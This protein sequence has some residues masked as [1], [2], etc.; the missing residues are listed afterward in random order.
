MRIVKSFF[1]FVFYSVLIAIAVGFFYI[2]TEDKEIDYKTVQAVEIT[3][4]G[5]PT[6]YYY[7]LLSNEDKNIYN[8][9]LTE[10]VK[11]PF[12]VKVPEM[13]E[14]QLG[15][16]FEAILN[17]N[18]TLFFMGRECK[19][20]QSGKKAYFY[21]GYEIDDAEYNSRLG[22]VEDVAETFLAS[23]FGVTDEYKIEK[24]VH[25][26]LIDTCDYDE[27][28]STVYDALVLG[29]AS[30]EGYSKAAKYLLDKKGIVNYV[31]CGVSQ[32]NAGSE[33]EKHMW[34]IVKLG[35]EYYNL[36]VTWDD[37]VVSD[38]SRTKKYVYFNVTD[39]FI[40]HTHSDFENVN[41]C[42][43]VSEN[44]FV[45]NGTYFESY[46]SETRAALALRIAE[47]ADRGEEKITVKFATE[48]AYSKAKSGLFDGD[49]IYDVLNTTKKNC[50]AQIVTDKV[51]YH[52]DNQ[53]YTIE[54]FFM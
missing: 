11:H 51:S 29:K 48:S 45:K 47:A 52:N 16:V 23:V 53:Y 12:R 26:Y 9:L 46:N 33:A 39:A 27:N 36:D 1:K 4:I 31:M 19:V 14:P 35:S 15:E 42:T 8:T 43:A 25:D 24:A 38:G 54:I 13:T 10:I 6:K 20:H 22:K 2:V 17:D 3:D 49:D 41:A 30:C 44:Y 50:T 21:P 37:P 32:V 34:N 40:S 18:P 7:S 28:C 5:S